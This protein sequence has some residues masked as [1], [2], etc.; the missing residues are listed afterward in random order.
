MAKYNETPEVVYSN[1]PPTRSRNPYT[2]QAERLY[3][4]MDHD[5]AENPL[6]FPKEYRYLKVE[7]KLVRSKGWSEDK[8][9]IVTDQRSLVDHLKKIFAKSGEL[10]R[11]H[12]WAIMMNQRHSIVGIHEVTIGEASASMVPPKEMFRACILANANVI[13]IAHN[14]PS[15]RLEFSQADLAIIKR[16]KEVSKMLDIRLLDFIAFGIGGQYV[17]AQDQGLV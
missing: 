3:Y 16:L 6:E 12:T 4:P 1:N 17:S 14:H 2:E 15:G 13:L 9:L 8:Q 7:T 5:K 11:E 10:D